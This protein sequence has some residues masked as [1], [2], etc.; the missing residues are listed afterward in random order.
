MQMSGCRSPARR[1][2]RG[3]GHEPGHLIIEGAG[4]PG[5]VT[6]PQHAATISQGSG[7]RTRG[8]SASMSTRN[9]SAAKARH[10]RRPS[11]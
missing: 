4:V 2:L 1:L 6:G 8:A 11:P 9:V 10:R 5:A 3:V 7:Q